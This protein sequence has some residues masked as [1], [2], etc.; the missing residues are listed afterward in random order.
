MGRFMV[1]TTISDL[2]D[3]ILKLIGEVG[4]PQGCLAQALF[5]ELEYMLSIWTSFTMGFISVYLTFLSGS[6][7]FVLLHHLKLIGLIVGISVVFGLSILSVTGMITNNEEYCFISSQYPE[8]QILFF[9]GWLWV[10]LL[11]N[12]ACITASVYYLRNSLSSDTSST[13]AFIRR[14]LFFLGAFVLVWI[15]VALD[16]I[17]LFT[18]GQV[19]GIK[20]LKALF[21]PLRGL[22]NFLA[23]YL[24]NYLYKQ[25]KNLNLGKS[26]TN[27]KSIDFIESVSSLVKTAKIGAPKMEKR[28]TSSVVESVG[29]QRTT[30]ENLVAINKKYVKQDY[31]K[32][33][34][35]K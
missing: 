18:N 4:S 9:Y 31:N 5:I 15:F 22:W 10:I 21:S 3:G 1:I 26:M 2:L 8:Y 12:I 16:N 14:L 33:H 7:N 13:R 20:F 35:L 17:I 6:L 32:L 29:S 27:S 25:E 23:Y 30:R 19:F 28:D 24:S 34:I 11:A